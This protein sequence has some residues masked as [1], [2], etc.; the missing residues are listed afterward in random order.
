MQQI[1]IDGNSICYQVRLASNPEGS[2]LFVHG[3]GGDHHK[4]DDLMQQLPQQFSGIAI[5]LPGHASSPGPL[6]QTIAEG[7]RLLSKLPSLLELPRPIWLVGHSMGSAMV[8][9]AALDF[10]GEIDGIILIGAGSRMRV[11]PSLLAALQAGQKDPAMISL[12]FSPAAPQALLEKEI[13]AFQQVPVE[14]L[15][16][17]FTSCDHFDRS[18]DVSQISLP[19]LMIVGEE[20]K[21]T[22]LKYSQRLQESIP[23]S[24]LVVIPQAGHM[25]M[26][27]KP[28]E[29]SQAIA[30][31]VGNLPTD[32]QKAEP[33][34]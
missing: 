1:F 25:V 4:W 17:D 27:E 30:E 23:N 8:I 2:L 22:P 24:E 9:S 31:F 20:D 15:Y 26:L 12:G 10:P 21:L 18:E 13:L 14:V 28:T 3:S 6:L 19:A 16:N 29:V 7:G 11:L 33:G 32:Q 34:M 5:D